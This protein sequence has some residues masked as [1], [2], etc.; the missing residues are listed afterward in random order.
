MDRGHEPPDHGPVVALAGRRIDDPDA[1]PRF[2]LENAR[3]VA[4]RIRAF[5]AVHNASAL[6]ASAACGADLLAHEQA[7]ELGL[8]RAVVLPF[9]TDAFRQ[10]S[11]TDRP[12]DWGP[13]YDAILRDTPATA[14]RTLDFQPGADE[15]YAAVNGALLDEAETIARL[16]PAGALRP[17][18]AVV[19]W[20]GQ[21]RGE[22]DLTADFAARARARGIPVSEILTT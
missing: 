16:A 14:I 22:G 4:E 12:G 11:V 13:R 5:L 20:E 9:P 18:L 19:V 6:V 3:R 7:R 17:V 8:D 10:S 15:A 21:T 1:P 2:P